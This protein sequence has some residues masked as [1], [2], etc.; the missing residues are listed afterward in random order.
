MA[1]DTI[2]VLA[3]ASF[4][5]AALCVA[6]VPAVHRATRGSPGHVRT[7]ATG[8]LVAAGLWAFAHGSALSATTLAAQETWTTIGLAVGAPLVTCW[9][10]LAYHRSRPGGRL[11]RRTAAL[12]AV[13][14]TVAAVGALSA[15]DWYVAGTTVVS[16]DG[17]LLSVPA[18]GVGLRLH[19]AY[20]A[21]VVVAGAASLGREALD[22]GRD[23]HGRAA[24]LVAAALV[25]GVTWGLWLLD[26][27]GP[28]AVDYTPIS[29]GVSALYVYVATRRYGLFGRRSVARDAVFDGLRDAVVVL[30]DRGAITDANPA[31]CRLFGVTDGDLGRRAGAVLPEGVPVERP[32]EDDERAT[33]RLTAD[34]EERFLEPRWTPLPTAGAGTVVSFRD[35]TER[36][37]V[38]RCYRAYVEHSRDVVVVADADG[39]LEYVSPAVERVL[40][41]DPERMEGTPIT[42]HIH[43][44]DRRDVAAPFAEALDTPG[45]S[46]RVT[47]RGRHADGGWRTLEGVGVNGFEDP[48]VGGFLVSLRDTTTR[49][50]YDQRLKVL[51]RVLRHDLRNELNVVLGYARALADADREAVARKG[52]TIRRAAERL[53]ELGERVR[54]V[55]RTLRDADHGGRPV[56]VSEV[57]E[58]VADLAGERYPRATVTTDCE[59]RVAAY[60]DG[61]LATALWNV[62]ENGIVHNDG[63]SPT[64]AIS[65]TT[66]CGTLELRVRDDGPGIPPAERSAVEAGRETQLEHASGLG[67]WLVRWALDGVD[68]ELAFP[69]TDA[70]GAVVLRL[71]AA[72]PAEAEDAPAT[73]PAE[74]AGVGGRR[75]VERPGGTGAAGTD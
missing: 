13:E 49:D 2:A 32:A 7:L 26:V 16:V 8:T 55:D 33:V 29:L 65:A 45:E 21:A 39:M 41:R 52:T 11:G 70:G 53:A 51:T 23:A 31:A 24:L 71:R 37:R 42:D 19:A 18:P 47:F 5:S 63:A 34:G 72:D 20:T 30:D 28:F 69:S 62:V 36:R 56:Y 43:P 10:A 27:P 58:A 6:V 9:F 12:L 40:G 35:V 60:A 73:S 61:L 38:E 54:G 48:R 64:V 4:L 74:W 44:D 3:G 1:V 22:G 15:G 59:E 68:G 75:D 66:E 57:V 25:P 67:L 17:A 50:R 14:P 46:V